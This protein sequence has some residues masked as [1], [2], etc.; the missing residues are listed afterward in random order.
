MC[1]ARLHA[2]VSVRSLPALIIVCAVTP[3]LA[4]ASSPTHDASLTYA[5][6]SSRRPST[7]DLEG[8]FANPRG[9]ALAGDGD[10]AVLL[11]AE[12][13][14]KRVHLFGLDGVQL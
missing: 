14:G 11:L 9:I 12:F 4:P 1:H 8:T 7:R 6:M 10:D 13:G 5:C 2:H 3:R